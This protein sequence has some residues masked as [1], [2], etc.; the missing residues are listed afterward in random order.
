M[1]AYL[2]EVTRLDKMTSQTAITRAFPSTI[3]SVG[4]SDF[5]SFMA[6][7]EKMLRENKT[8]KKIHFGR[9]FPNQWYSDSKYLTP[10]DYPELTTIVLE[11]QPEIRKDYT[12]YREFFFANY[13]SILDPIYRLADWL[14]VN[15]CPKLRTI[16]IEFTDTVE[17]I[18]TYYNGD[19]EFD[20]EYG[21]FLEKD[22]DWQSEE[23][24]A[25]LLVERFFSDLE[26]DLTWITHHDIQFI[27]PSSL[28][29]RSN[30]PCCC[31]LVQSPSDD[32]RVPDQ[33]AFNAILAKYDAS[34]NV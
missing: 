24:D 22:T 10:T 8:L 18:W 3:I 27:L 6:N 23:L 21:Y 19:E 14:W 2:D 32:L 4:T 33:D 13:E 28:L 30:A 20:R 25:N 26:V 34:R 15:G 11:I 9:S 31:K 1:D 5:D 17:V 12:T 16:R 29:S 7:T